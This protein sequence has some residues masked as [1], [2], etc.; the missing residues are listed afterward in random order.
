MPQDADIV[1][2]DKVA[3]HRQRLVS[4]K[5]PVIERRVA[6]KR[7]AWCAGH[8][9][10]FESAD[11]ATPRRA[12]DL[13]FFDYMGLDPTDLSIVEESPKQIVWRSAN[14]CPTLAACKAEG[15]DTR[16]VCRGAYEKSTQALISKLDPSLRFLGDYDRIRPHA[17]ACLER[18]VRIDFDAMMDLALEE[19]RASL[20]EGNKG[21]GA[22][23]AM[24]DR[25]LAGA[26]DTAKTERDPSLHG[27]VNAMRAAIAATGDPNLSGAVLFSTCE[28][29]PMCASLAVWANVSA[30][31]YGAS[32]AE[33]AA[34]GLSRIEVGAAEIAERAPV[35]LEVIGGVRRE[36]CLELYK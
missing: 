10:L 33:T 11:E 32:I 29:C 31:V 6:E 15:L 8:P 35:L 1:F 27:E 12:F 34:L 14:P 5:L 24:G 4:E 7:L 16:K 36:A 17:D 9:E 13:L 28:P 22:V 18:I 25:V 19:A 26:H 21:Y 23:V 3:R 2:A 30:I 20:A